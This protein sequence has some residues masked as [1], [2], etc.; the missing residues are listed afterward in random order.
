[1]IAGHPPLHTAHLMAKIF[2]SYRREDTAAAAGRLY[3]RL[4]T[5]YGKD[6][7][8]MDVDTI[9]PGE[10]FSDVVQRTVGSC[11]ILLALVG[12]RWLNAQDSTGQTRLS[13][14]DDWVRLEIATALKRDVRVI[15]VLIN[16]AI[17]PRRSDLPEDLSDLAMRQAI[18]VTHAHF[19]TDVDRLLQTLDKVLSRPSTGSRPAGSA[20]SIAPLKNAPVNA[21]SSSSAVAATEKSAGEV[22]APWAEDK[23]LLAL[24]VAVAVINIPFANL[25]IPSSFPHWLQDFGSGN[26]MVRLG[27]CFGLVLVVWNAQA[28]QDLRKPWNL[29]FL[30]ASV[31]SALAASW[32][33]DKFQSLRIWGIVIAGAVCLALA[34]RLLFRSRWVQAI[35]AAIV[36]PA[37]FYLFLISVGRVFSKAVSDPLVNYMPLFWQLGFLLGIFGT[38]QLK[39]KPFWKSL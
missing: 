21:W 8:F 28:W 6:Q 5:R 24:K 38:A 26:A 16:G 25:S 12:D 10:R 19:H 17:V 14:P 33:G 2:I 20:T 9:E 35:S 39:I 32:F 22:A 31:G 36:A 13:N 23:K 3:D 11:D 1:M 29:L 37:A 34:Q 4:L 27:V 7:L 18:D 15:P 30:A